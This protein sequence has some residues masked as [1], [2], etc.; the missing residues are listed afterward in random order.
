MTRYER[1]QHFGSHEDAFPLPTARSNGFQRRATSLLYLNDCAQGGRTHFDV[2][3]VSSPPKRGSVLVF[4]P[5]LADGAPDGRTLHCAQHAEDEKWVVQQWVACGVGQAAA[6]GAGAGE[7][8]A[9]DATVG[10]FG[11]AAAA[12]GGAAAGGIFGR[13]AAAS[14]SDAAAPGLQKAAAQ[15]AAAAPAAAGKPEKKAG[16]G[17]GG[18]GG[19]KAAGSKGGQQNA[20]A[21]RKIR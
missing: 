21:G 11:K 20:G 10:L 3:G 17:F 8:E 4:F 5:A 12:G 6:A 18:G 19:G 13:S 14:S 9:L 2:L 7:P 15:P 1:G 16:K